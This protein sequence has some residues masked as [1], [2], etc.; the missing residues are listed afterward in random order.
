MAEQPQQLKNLSTALND[1]SAEGIEILTSEPSRLFGLMLW[2]IAAMLLSAVL[3][4]FIGKSPEI[5]SAQGA[6]RPDSE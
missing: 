6:I 1:H 3:W 5:V 2:L 4:S